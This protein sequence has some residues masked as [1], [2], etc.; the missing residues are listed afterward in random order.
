MLRL[1][2]DMSIQLAFV[3]HNKWDGFEDEM[4]DNREF[5]EVH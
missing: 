3:Y 2:S 4:I 1:E 5:I